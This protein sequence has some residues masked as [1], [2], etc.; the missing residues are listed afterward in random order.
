MVEGVLENSKSFHASEYILSLTD[1]RDQQSKEKN[2]LY[3][4]RS[5]F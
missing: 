1:V 3:I 4:I 5:S 2:I